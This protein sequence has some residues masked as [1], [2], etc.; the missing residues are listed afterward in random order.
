MPQPLHIHNFHISDAERENENENEIEID[1]VRKVY[2]N[3]FSIT[4]IVIHQ[5]FFCEWLICSLCMHFHFMLCLFM[6]LNEWMG[7]GNYDNV[8]ALCACCI[9]SNLNDAKIADLRRTKIFI[10]C[11]EDEASTTAELKKVVN[12]HKL[13]KLIKKL[14]TTKFNFLFRIST[15]FCIDSS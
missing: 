12:F 2:F 3:I 10:I 14:L 1:T 5:H 9:L 6:S 8:T 4:Q 13:T 7:V 11:D 15:M